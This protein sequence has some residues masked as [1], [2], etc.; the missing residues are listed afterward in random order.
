MRKF[1]YVIFKGPLLAIDAFWSIPFGD[2]ALRALSKVRT[3]IVKKKVDARIESYAGKFTTTFI[4]DDLDAAA[5]DWNKVGCDM[6]KA[7]DEYAGSAK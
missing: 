2:D 3:D 6:R 4:K 7:I 5:Y 1:I